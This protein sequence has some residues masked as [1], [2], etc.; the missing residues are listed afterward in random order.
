MGPLCP[1]RLPRLTRLTPASAPSLGTSSRSAQDRCASPRSQSPSAVP[2]ASHRSPISLCPRLGLQGNLTPQHNKGNIT[3][4]TLK[5]A[6]ITDM[7][8]KKDIFLNSK[9]I[10]KI[11]SETFKNIFLN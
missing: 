11:I 1:P 10:F 7:N 8:L 6:C 5:Q 2:P 3:I 4:Q 9:S